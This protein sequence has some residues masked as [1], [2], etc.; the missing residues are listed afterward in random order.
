V[1]L[2]EVNGARVFVEDTG[3]P[4]GH[5]Q[6]DALL[7]GHG[8]LFSGRSFAGQVARLKDR[9]RC[10]TIDWRGQGR[11]PPTTSGYD[12]DTLTQDVLGVIEALDLGAVHYVGLSMGGFVGMRLGARH[13]EVLHSLTLI[14]TSADREDPSNARRYRLL[15]M[16]YGLVGPRP[17]KSQVLP[18]LFGPTYLADPRSKAEIDTWLAELSGAERSGIKKAIHG[19]IA[20]EPIHAEIGRITVPTLV[21]V[22]A[23]DE[24]APVAKSQAIAEAVPGARLEILPDAG[25]SSSIEQPEAVADLIAR[26]IEERRSSA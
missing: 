10:V 4:P 26:F 16:V 5:P 13:P 23:D 19:V 11:T 22:G 3:P 1:P 7:F 25:H 15:A 6:A 12:M 14:E 21:V 24:A 18:V 20:R 17:V 2:L 8:V 9:Y